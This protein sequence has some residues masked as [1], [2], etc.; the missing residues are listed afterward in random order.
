MSRRDKLI[1]RFE[2]LPKD[3]TWNELVRLFEIFGFTINNKG[4]TSGSR[5][6]FEKD[7]YSFDIHKPHP[8]NIIKEY[9]MKKALMFLRD[10]NFIQD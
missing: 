5:I 2:Q 4:K 10:N 1:Q 8:S 9:V 3:F 6:V 7:E